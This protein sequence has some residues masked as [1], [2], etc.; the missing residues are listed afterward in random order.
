MLSRDFK[1]LISKLDSLTINQRR[2][3]L[4]TI[5]DEPKAESVN[6]VESR[7][8]ET[9][10]CP[11]CS[12][13]SVCRWGKS[14]GLQRYRCKA[15]SKTFNALTGSS[16]ARLRFKDVWLKYSQCL[17]DG[18][19]VRKAAKICGIDSSTAFRWR[20]RFL[21]SPAKEKSDKMVGIVEADEAFFHESSKGNR[22]LT[23]RPARKRGQSYKKQH[24]KLVPV[25]LVRDRNGTEADFVFEKIEKHAVHDCLRPLMSDEIVLCSDGNSIYKTFAEEE[26]IPHKRIIAL[27]KV[28]VIEKI[29]H[30]QNLNAYISRLRGWLRRFNGVATKYLGNYLGWR[31]IIEK[32]NGNLPAE[33]FLRQAMGRNHQQLTLT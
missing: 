14:D 9:T 29:F 23:H 5:S 28:N 22:H 21:Q 32:I 25:L 7:Q 24:K 3:L 2:K 15:C 16:L 30:I 18:F 33:F 8:S 6:I 26:Q 10:S 19:T 12:C 17:V 1:N 4:S 27:D 31:R 11:H 20:H 13:E